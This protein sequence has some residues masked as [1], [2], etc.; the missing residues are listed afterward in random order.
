MKLVS[1][2][3]LLQLDYLLLSSFVGYFVTR[4]FLGDWGRATNYARIVLEVSK[5][6]LDKYFVSLLGY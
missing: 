4:P 3:Q 6:I 5:G 2:T 1:I